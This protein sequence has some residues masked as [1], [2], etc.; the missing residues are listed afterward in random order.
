MNS[1]S[2]MT[3]IASLLA[4]LA[5][6]GCAGQVVDLSVV[7]RT[8]Q[9]REVELDGWGVYNEVIGRPGPGQTAT[10]QLRVPGCRLPATYTI[11]AGELRGALTVDAFAP[12]AVTYE[13]TPEGIKKAQ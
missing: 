9:T 11:E 1:V 10:Y 4:A 3:C 13:I 12:E 8:Q 5:L 6:V 2:R 7:N